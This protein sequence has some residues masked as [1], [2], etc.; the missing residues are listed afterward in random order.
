MNTEKKKVETLAVSTLGTQRTD[1]TDVKA[2]LIME[3]DNER[4]KRSER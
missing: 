1:E 3:N 4:N 2:L